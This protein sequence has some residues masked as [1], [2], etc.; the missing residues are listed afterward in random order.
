MPELT[1]RTFS[2]DGTAR[3]VERDY[4]EVTLITFSERKFAGG[5]RNAGILA[6]HGDI[7]AFID[8]D[9]TA[10]TNWVNAIIQAHGAPHAA[11]GGAI[12]NGGHGGVA[13]WAAFF[14]EFSEWMP[15]GSARWLEDMAAAN[16]SYKR[17]VLEEFGPFIEDTYCSDSEL[18][19][20]MARNGHRIWFEPSVLVNH[21]SIDKLDAFLKHEFAH[22][23]SFARVRA[24]GQHFSFGRRTVYAG[25]CWLIPFALLARQLRR[26]ARNRTHVATFIKSL[27]LL[28]AGLFAW[29]IGEGVGYA[30]GAFDK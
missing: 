9:C 2:T 20:R 15:G 19:W 18:H 12:A 3:V 28:V 14:C 30:K 1:K 4:P 26:H 25:L 24:S 21:H 29:G 6:A 23:R 8:A 16:I 5:A 7:I 17:S 11:I 27:P 10:A 22:G 13:S